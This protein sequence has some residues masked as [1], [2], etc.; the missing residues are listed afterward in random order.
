MEF[1]SGIYTSDQV[2]LG[3]RFDQNAVDV[4]APDPSGSCGIY[5]SGEKNYRDAIS[6]VH[7]KAI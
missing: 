4:T 2:Q 7:Q 6:G 3:A 1:K 5:Q